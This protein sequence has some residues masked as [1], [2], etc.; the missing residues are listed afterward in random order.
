[1][2][3][4]Q[5]ITNALFTGTINGQ[6]IQA[7]FSGDANGQNPSVT[8]QIPGHTVVVAIYTETSSTLIRNFEGT[9]TGGATGT[10]EMGISGNYFSSGCD[11]GGPRK[12]TVVTGNIDC[13]QDGVEIKGTRQGTDYRPRTWKDLDNNNHGTWTGSSTLQL[14]NRV[15]FAPH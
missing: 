5:A 8:I 1:W 3:P 2:T 7:T 12:S 10:L 13:T 6:A 15:P 4:G 14:S 11:G 9:Y